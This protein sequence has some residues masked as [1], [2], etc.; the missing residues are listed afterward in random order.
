VLR[1]APQEII[2]T[3]LGTSLDELCSNRYQIGHRRLVIS[4]APLVNDGEV[5]AGRWGQVG[6]GVYT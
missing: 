5:V 1:A 3:P 6:V 2:V 4:S